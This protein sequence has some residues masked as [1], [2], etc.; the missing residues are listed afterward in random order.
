[1]PQCPIHNVAPLL[2]HSGN[3][4][5][6]DQITHYDAQSLHAIALIRPE[7]ILL[8]AGADSLPIWMGGEILAQ[9]IGAWAGAHALDRGEPVRLGFLLGSRKLQF[10]APAIPVGTHLDI[11]IHLSLQD[12]TGMGVF[13]CILQCREPAPGF[14]ESLPPGKVL[15]QGAMNVFSPNNDAIL[16]KTLGR[17]PG[18]HQS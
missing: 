7:C 5:L 8:P 1:M 11:H 3:M 17:N 13:D 9:G 4:V 14:A 6:L 18:A 16:A 15:V 10:G 12:E 2:P